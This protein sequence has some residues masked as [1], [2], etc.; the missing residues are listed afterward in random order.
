MGQ[1]QE[2]VGMGQAGRVSTRR[3]AMSVDAGHA[4]DLRGDIARRV[5]GPGADLTRR[6]HR[7]NGSGAGRGFFLV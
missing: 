6:A 2:L 7:R 3:I 1:T 5:G 4:A